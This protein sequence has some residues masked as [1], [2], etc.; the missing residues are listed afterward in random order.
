MKYM[1]IFKNWRIFAL[2]MLVSASVILLLCD[3]EDIGWLI[4][5]K[6]AGLAMMH[7]SAWLH[8]RWQGKMNE[9]EVFNID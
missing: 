3:S 7:L 9:L 6:A 8:G 1:A 5:T 2:T 4:A